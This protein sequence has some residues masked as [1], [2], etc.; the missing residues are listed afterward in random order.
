MKTQTIT[1]IGLDR[2]GASIGLALKHSPLDVVVIGH[3]ADATK[4]KIAKETVL[5]IDQAEWNLVNAARKADILIIT[6]PVADLESILQVIGGELQSHTLVLDFSSLKRLGLDLAEQHLH[7]G[8]YVGAMPILAAP[9]LADGRSDTSTATPDLF[10]NSAFCLMPSPN[11]DPQAVE[12]AV[13]FGLLLGALPYFVDPD[14]YDSLVQGS[15]TLPGLVSLAMFNTMQKATG[16]R[17][18]LRFAGLPFALMTRPL[19]NEQDIPLHALQNK[20]ATLRWL[21]AMMDELKA[22]RR[23]IYEE[24]DEV[25]LALTEQLATEREKW[26]NA[27]QKNDWDERRSPP[28]RPRTISQ[29]LFGGFARQGD[30]D[31]E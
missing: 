24:N 14:E 3:D 12:T 28:I 20:E 15:E 29:H 30:D 2:M 17:D 11:A 5:A 4:G 22:V 31:D 6:T 27:R 19:Q 1:I 18:M 16:W 8:H 21:D 7:Q 9:Y 10:R 26:I 23:L 13:N 25:F